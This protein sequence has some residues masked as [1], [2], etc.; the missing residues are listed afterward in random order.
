MC[1]RARL[2]LLGLAPP[3]PLSPEQGPKDKPQQRK[4]I[5]PRNISYCT[6]S[7]HSAAYSLRAL[8]Q[9]RA[10]P[11]RGRREHAAHLQRACGRRR[12]A[13]GA[14]GRHPP[15]VHAAQVGMLERRGEAGARAWLGVGLGL[16]LGVGFGFGF[17]FGL[18]LGLG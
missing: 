15:R 2:V 11:E 13:K 10:V 7:L 6:C 4:K 12:A 9:D 14:R 3:L 16:G 1:A 18:G 17:G 8:E 5:I